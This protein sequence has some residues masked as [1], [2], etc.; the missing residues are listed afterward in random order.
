MI[1]CMHGRNFVY[2]LWC[3]FAC[4]L[5]SRR[6]GFQGYKNQKIRGAWLFFFKDISE[7]LFGFFFVSSLI[8]VDF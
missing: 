6:G 5:L 2:G 3:V 1:M 8:Y 7:E 4:A